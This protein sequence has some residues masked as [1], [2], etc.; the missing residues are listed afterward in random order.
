MRLVLASQSSADPH[1][2]APTAERLVNCY[3]VPAPEGSIAPMVIRSVPS[4]RR[5]VTLPGPFLR[6]MARIDG[7]LYAISAGGLHRIN[8][9]GT[10]V[11]LAALPDDPNAVIVGHRSTVTITAAGSYFVWNGS[12][13]TQPAGGPLTD[14]GS[15][16]FL[17]Q[18]TLLGERNGARVE[19]TS[20]GLPQTRNGLYFATAEARDDKIVRIM[21]SGPYVMIMKQHSAEMWAAS[22]DG[23]AL[24]GAFIRVGGS[25]LD[26]GLR[27]FN[28][29]CWTPEG[30]F[31]VG[32]DNLAYFAP[33]GGLP[34]PVSSATVNQALATG[35]P[36]HCFYYEDRGHRFC[37]I[38]FSD[39][40]AWVYDLTMQAWHERSSGPEHEPWNVICAAYCY[41]Q[42]HL[43]DLTGRIWRLGSAPIDADGPLRRTIVSRPLYNDN[44][45][46]NVALVEFEGLFGKYEVEEVAPNWLTDENGFP[47]L[48]ENG[49]YITPESQMAIQYHKRPGRMWCRFSKDGGHNW[50]LPKP[51]DIGKVGEYRARARYVALGQF[52]N[53][54]V[55]VNLT[56]PV[57]VPLMAEA[58]VQVS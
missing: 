6:D 47:I 17:D 19:W 20:P 51:K 53:M 14:I 38:R 28:L 24:S 13:L 31:L 10:S 52:Y 50:G 33:A 22:S 15:V 21:A 48:D 46:F 37:V 16:T 9:N 43:G 36:T 8:E 35:E 29:M 56:D 40:P 57:D 2:L 23:G 11:Y 27:D 1:N 3:A 54:T 58:I 44:E 7:T 42:W 12:T 5:G 26:R 49:D 25:V 18:F 39:R 41:G 55:E 34:A 30:V 32:E 4:T 45:P